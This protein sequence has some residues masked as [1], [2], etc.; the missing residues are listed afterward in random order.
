MAFYGAKYPKISST[1][2]VELDEN[3]LIEPFVVGTMARF[4]VIAPSTA[5]RVETAGWGAPFGHRV[6]NPSGAL[7]VGMAVALNT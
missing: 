1:R 7:A 4:E 6:R 2:S 5:F 3:S